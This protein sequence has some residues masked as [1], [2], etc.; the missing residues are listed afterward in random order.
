MND[1]DS[2]ANNEIATLTE[3]K[4]D[5]KKKTFGDSPTWIE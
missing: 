4:K 3:I 2:E 5:L 1:D